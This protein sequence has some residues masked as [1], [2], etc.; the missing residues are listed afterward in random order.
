M[1]ASTLC[2]Q[3]CTRSVRYCKDKLGCLLRTRHCGP[4]WSPDDLPHDG[5]P[6]RQVQSHSS[7]PSRL[8][9]FIKYFPIQRFGTSQQTTVTTLL[10]A[11]FV[12]HACVQAC[13]PDMSLDARLISGSLNGPVKGLRGV[14][15]ETRGALQHAS[16][17]NARAQNRYLFWVAFITASPSGSS[18][19]K[20]LP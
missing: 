15:A 8:H 20:W 16:G 18:A 7:A 10:S 17:Y 2:L 3:V 14:R 1:R 6:G 19:N 4:L 12:Y 11:L 9:S 13:P 5:Q